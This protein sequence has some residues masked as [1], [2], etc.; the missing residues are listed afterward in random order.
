MG[1]LG[2][3]REHSRNQLLQELVGP[4]LTSNELAQQTL[5][6]GR[7]SRS[8]RSDGGAGT[9]GGE[10]EGG[11][12]RSEGR[13]SSSF[14]RCRS[15]PKEGGLTLDRT[16][17]GGRGRTGEEVGLEPNQ[18]RCFTVK[19]VGNL[20]QSISADSREDRRKIGGLPAC[21]GSSIDGIDHT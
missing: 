18:L 12:S 10:A 9:S 2:T 1:K 19:L 5:H 6:G 8:N 16:P 17:T 13:G 3:Y 20:I 4:S 11:R 21:M 7:S 14:E 15:I